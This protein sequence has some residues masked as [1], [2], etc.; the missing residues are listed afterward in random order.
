MFLIKLV[1]SKFFTL[2]A[3]LGVM[4]LFCISV[5]ATD[6][7]VSTSGSA[8]NNGSLSSPFKT[9]K[10]AADIMYPGDTCYIM[11]GTY[12]ETVIPARSGELGTPITFTNYNNEGVTISG[13]DVVTTSWSQYS[14]NIYKTQI[15]LGLGNNNQ[16]F[17]NGELNDLAR[18]PNNTGSFPDKLLQPNLAVID[19]TTTTTVSTIKDAD[20]IGN[21]SN[22][23]YGATVWC[24]T[25]DAWAAQKSTVTATNAYN[26]STHTL[27]FPKFP[28]SSVT[29]YIP[30]ATNKYYLSGILNVLDVEKEWVYTG[31][32][33]Y[34]YKQGGESPATENV[35]YKSRYYAFE[36]S[37]K[38]YTN[39]SGI[40]IVAAGINTNGSTSY[41]TFDRMNASYIASGATNGGINLYGTGLTI[42]NSTLKYS[43]DY[44]IQI[45]GTNNSVINNDISYG[46]YD[47]GWNPIVYM[48]EGT[49][50]LVSHNSIYEAGRGC[51][52]INY[53]YGQ[54]I[55]EYN[56]MYNAGRL[57]NDLGVF[58]SGNLDG[59]YT[60]I[61]H[62]YVHDN[63]ASPIGDGIYYDNYNSNLMIDHNVVWNTDT[64]LRLNFPNSG[65]LVYNNTL[66]GPVSMISSLGGIYNGEMYGAKVYNNILTGSITFPNEVSVGNSLVSPQNP[67][68]VDSATN[69]YHIQGTSPA[70]DTGIVVPGITDGFVDSNP[71]M[72]AYEYNGTDWV[73]GCDLEKPP[74]V[75]YAS[76]TT[77]YMN[78]IKSAGFEDLTLNNWATTDSK[79]ANLKY[80]S[81][82]SGDS[83]FARS[84]FYGLRLGYGVDGVVQTVTGLLPN[85]KYVLSAWLKVFGAENI[86][87][88]VKNY[89]ETQL[90]SKCTSLTWQ[91]RRVEFTTGSNNT[92]AD[93]Y[94][95][96]TTA[97][98]NYACAD[99]VSLFM[100][101]PIK[102][103][104]SGAGTIDM[105]STVNNLSYNAIEP[106]TS[107]INIIKVNND[108][109][110]T[111]L[112]GYS[113][114]NTPCV[115][116][117]TS[118]ENII[119]I[120]PNGLMTGK[121]PGVATITVT[122]TENGSSISKSFIAYVYKFSN[123][124][125]NFDTVTGAYGGF[126]KSGYFS[127]ATNSA[128]TSKQKD[129]YLGWG[130]PSVRTGLA[131]F[132]FNDDPT[133]DTI[134]HVI[135]IHGADDIP[136]GANLRVQLHDSDKTPSTTY[137]YI[138]GKPTVVGGT[139]YNTPT[140]TKGWHQ[141]LL[142]FPTSKVLSCY[143]DG[144]LV[145]TFNAEHY[146]FLNTA[147]I[148]FMASG[149]KAY[150]DDV[151][152]YQLSDMGTSIPTFTKTVNSVETDITSTGLVSG[153]INGKITVANYDMVNDYSAMLM[154]ALYKTIDGQA[155]LIS[156]SQSPLIDVI[157]TS[158]K[159]KD[160]VLTTTLD[161]PATID[162]SYFVK[163]FVW[164]DT[165]G[166]KPVDYKST[167]FGTSGFIYP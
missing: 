91:K 155:K 135:D 148:R 66:V 130:K 136:G 15:S 60:R 75:E 124:D 90:S 162:S 89:G 92:S 117:I 81:V 103:S 44:M 70:V 9:I 150:Y 47:A 156:F 7:Y 161:I 144:M 154:M 72:G 105:S 109:S 46:D 121:N 110:Q 19:S 39:V 106:T 67:M 13:A 49:G 50:H 142:Y 41:C 29:N 129:I 62:N 86:E 164:S 53:C 94:I 21:Y 83:S 141:V 24:V 11:G 119:R 45:K 84:N 166:L 10:Q 113:S 77:P 145:K 101:E 157:A 56:D 107:Q 111:N 132:W 149:N 58:Y 42:K 85:T 61:H 57:T 64:A 73:A 88:G 122:V 22:F 37:G 152:Y 98:G 139:Y 159:T 138:V 147:F 33:L 52:G 31:G 93:I 128:D 23:W 127:W 16:I 97:L 28:S 30:R 143:I 20:L 4:S 48:Y 1:K 118:D 69:N 115:E 27:T 140:R 3:V 78:M 54:N 126:A 17:V 114:A 137:R 131:E 163:L 25:G 59:S 38:S 8:S 40:N 32:Y 125:L 116:Y 165:E 18:W 99:D 12:R 151:R 95:R 35:E 80:S 68:F 104:V 26:T 76:T 134:K 6:Y 79:T 112:T 55:I 34:L 167:K 120:S 100:Q 158:D 2:S 102:S 82:W 71:D 87:I 51:I 153:T 63:F 133:D 123:V 160:P 43:A 36:L 65:N 108:L 74:I 5:S 146:G 14:G 96:K